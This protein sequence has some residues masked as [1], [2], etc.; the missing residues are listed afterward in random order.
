MSRLGKTLEDYLSVRRALGFKL[1]RAGMLLPGFVAYV[2][3]HGS[4]FITTE[5]AL[6]WAMQP[7]DAAPYW[8]AA[9]LGLVRGFAKYVRGFDPRNEV[10]SAELI[11]YRKPRSTP[12]LY[13]D[14][15]IRALLEVCQ[16]IR[17]PLGAAT[18]E[19][20]FGLL[21]ATGMRVGEA[22]GL[23]RC[24]FKENEA[25]LVVRHSKFNKSREVLLHSTT[26]EALRAYA[27]KRN[28]V[29]GRRRSPSFFLSQAGTRLFSQNVWQTFARLRK[30]AGLPLRP[31][32]PRIHDLRHSFAVHTLLRWYRAGVDVEPRI[33]ALSTYLGH[34]SPSTTYW[35]LTAAPELM[36][37]AAQRLE[38]AQG[39][40]P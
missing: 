18:Y 32:P 5:L 17:G 13:T 27:R 11:P 14:A 12:Y 3:S 26:V 28:R 21:A 36:G 23:D 19:T 29:V 1:Q 33:A 7:D 8:W 10:P 38:D 25:L 22:I 30:W 40:L 2:E 20:L 37:L 34:V 4:T 31:R 6:Q 9:R 15:D 24:D 16:R 39:E 35:Y